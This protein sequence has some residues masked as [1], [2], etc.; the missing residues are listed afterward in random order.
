MTR[1]AAPPWFSALS[2]SLQ[3][4][5]PDPSTSGLPHSPS[6]ERKKRQKQTDSNQMLTVRHSPAKIRM[7]CGS[8]HKYLSGCGA[9]HPAST[10]AAPEIKIMSSRPQIMTASQRIVTG[11]GRLSWF[12]LRKKDSFPQIRPS[13]ART[14]HSRA[15]P[16][17]VR[18]TAIP[19]HLKP[20]VN[21]PGSAAGAS[22]AS[23]ASAAAR[24]SSRRHPLLPDGASVWCTRRSGIQG[25]AGKMLEETA[26]CFGFDHY[27]LH[28]GF[29]F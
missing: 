6:Q 28:P 25:V 18:M 23:A 16:A 19:W 27:S 21:E 20:N 4:K 1:W 17:A 26:Y 24:W 5:Q 13:R 15:S 7:G 29:T 9:H 12:F 22:A 14:A 2:W 8:P 3:A 11:A 10:T